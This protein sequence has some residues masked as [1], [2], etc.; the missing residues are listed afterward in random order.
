MDYVITVWMP[1]YYI[2]RWRLICH[3]SC[4]CSWYVVANSDPSHPQE[5]ILFCQ[6]FT[7]R[8][9]PCTED[10]QKVFGEILYIGNSISV[11]QIAFNHCSNSITTQNFC[12]TFKSYLSCATTGPVLQDL[13][14]CITNRWQH[15]ILYVLSLSHPFLITQLLEVGKKSILMLPFNVPPE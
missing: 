6:L 3:R 15:S 8:C 2:S 12:C 5:N 4:P 11:Y 1:P 10:I 9:P 14:N 13:L 7:C